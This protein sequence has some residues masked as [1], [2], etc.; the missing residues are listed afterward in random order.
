MNTDTPPADSYDKGT[1]WDAGACSKRDAVKAAVLACG[2]P[3]GMAGETLGVAVSGR[4]RKLVQK[5]R[6]RLGV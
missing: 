2:K 5:Y 3:L 6:P 4:E 1:A